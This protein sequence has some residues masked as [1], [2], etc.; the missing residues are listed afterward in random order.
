MIDLKNI[1]LNFILSTGRTGSTLLSTMLNVHSNIIS[2][3]EEPFSYNLYPKYQSISV[4]NDKTI[5]EFVFDFFLFSEGKLKTQFGSKEDLTLLLKEHQ[6]TLTASRAIKLAYFAFFPQK[7]KTNVDTIVDKELKFHHF[8]EEINTFYP[9]S[10]F[11]LL[12]R[13]PRDNV[14]IKLKKVAKQ[15]RYGNLYFFSKMWAYEYG[16]LLKKLNKIEKN[17]VIFVKYEDLINDTE[18]VLKNIC[19]F[20][21][22]SFEPGMLNYHEEVKNILGNKKTNFDKSTGEHIDLLH[23]GLISKISNDKIDLWK[24]EFTKKEYNNI[25]SICNTTADA[26]NYKADICLKERDYKI[27]DI[28]NYLLFF[29]NKIFIPKTYYSLPYRIKYIIKYMKY[30]KLVKKG[31]FDVTKFIEKSLPK[32]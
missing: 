16:I 8:L 9:T 20:L 21:N 3:S 10:K 30:G 4:W 26:L 6:S 29:Y 5:D 23:Q 19:T 24:K 28:K 31:E 1:S 14:L 11:I 22:I 27:Q 25:W 32:K 15:G 18:N 13:D 2:T 12:T 7:D 17:R